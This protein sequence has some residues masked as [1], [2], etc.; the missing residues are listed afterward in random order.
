[1]DEAELTRFGKLKTKASIK[2]ELYKKEHLSS[3]ALQTSC[4]DTATHIG[5]LLL[6]FAS[7]GGGHVADQIN[8]DELLKQTIRTELGEVLLLLSN[9]VRGAMLLV[10]D[11]V[12]GKRAQAEHRRLNPPAVVEEIIPTTEG[13]ENKSP[14]KAGPTE[15]THGAHNSTDQQPADPQEGGDDAIM[16]GDSG[17]LDFGD[18]AR[19]YTD[20]DKPRGE[21]GVQGSQAAVA[22]E[23]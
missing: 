2:N 9:K 20:L 10:K 15:R 14:F 13:S 1:V 12:E 18:F 21:E 16:R 17:N 23:E 6:D 11:I 4:V 19:R 22:Q 7:D 3:L 5:A 8:G